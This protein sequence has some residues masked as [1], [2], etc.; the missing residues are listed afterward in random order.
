MF[1]K[2]TQLLSIH[3]S[4]NSYLCRRYTLLPPN[5]TPFLPNLIVVWYKEKATTF[6]NITHNLCL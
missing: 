3:I 6:T 4:K 1:F 2:I 5:L